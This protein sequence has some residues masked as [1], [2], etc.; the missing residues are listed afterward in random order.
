VEYAADDVDDDNDADDV[1]DEKSITEEWARA[2]SDLDQNNL[3]GADFYLRGRQIM[4]W[5][6]DEPVARVIR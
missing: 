4:V 5:G 2:H 1:A 6:F 3:I